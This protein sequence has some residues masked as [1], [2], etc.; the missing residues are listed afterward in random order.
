M[1]RGLTRHRRWCRQE[2]L[3]KTGIF[4]CAKNRQG[5]KENRQELVDQLQKI[6]DEEQ[7]A[8]TA[9]K[10]IKENEQVVLSLSKENTILS[11]EQ[12][13]ITDTFG[14]FEDFELANRNIYADYLKSLADDKDAGKQVNAD[15]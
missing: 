10:T 12:K 4:L 13:S 14:S 1:R 3:P 7:E 9:N 6:E 5:N 15:D 8:R 2:A 11:Y